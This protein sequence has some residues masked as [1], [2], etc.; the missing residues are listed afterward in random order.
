MVT[1]LLNKDGH[2]LSYSEFLGKYGIPVTPKE[3]SIVFD[4]IPSGILTL[5]QGCDSLD[6]GVQVTSA[7]MSGALTLTDK[8]CNNYHI[9]SHCQETSVPST[10]AFWEAKV[11]NINWKL[12]WNINKKYSV[13]NKIREVSF[14]IAQRIYPVKKELSRFREMDELCVFCKAEPETVFHLF[15]DRPC[16]KLFWI[17]MEGFVRERMGL[18][19]HFNIE[20]I[21]LY[22]ERSIGP[23]ETFVLNLFVLLGKYHIHKSKWTEK[24]HG[25]NN[26]EWKVNN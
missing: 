14:K 19:I 4:A 18:S 7:P 16:V 3:Y 6:K 20:D 21:G 8:K 2:L 13:T 12:V 24:P 23:K 25:F 10:K 15:Y 1:Q 26:L 5:V 11:Q 17:D 9:R 22:V